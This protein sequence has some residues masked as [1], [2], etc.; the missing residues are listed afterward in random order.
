M[1][2]LPSLAG[3]LAGPFAGG[4]ALASDWLVVRNDIL[5]EPREPA[6]I[7]ISELQETP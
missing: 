1:R 4:R 2:R 5:R 7:N 3:A 6:P